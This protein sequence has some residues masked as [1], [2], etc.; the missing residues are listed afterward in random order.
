MTLGRDVPTHC[1]RCGEEIPDPRRNKR[2]CGKT[3]RAENCHERQGRR[4]DRNKALQ[5]AARGHGG[6][7]RRRNGTD[8]YVLPEDIEQIRLMFSGLRGSKAA[9]ERLEA[10]LVRASERIGRAA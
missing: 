1:E 2:F 9:R 7:V 6:R 3:C 4:G 8:L 10:K 5:G